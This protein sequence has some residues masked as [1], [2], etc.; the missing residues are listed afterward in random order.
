MKETVYYKPQIGRETKDI[1]REITPADQQYIKTVMTAY[2]DL[3][4][5]DPRPEFKEWFNQPNKKLPPKKEKGLGPNT[6]KTWCE[7]IISKLN[8]A[9]NRRDLSPKQCEGIEMLSQAISEIYDRC[10]SIEF[11][12]KLNKDD[13]NRPAGFG[14]LFK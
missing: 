1:L 14:K 9:P 4:T 7:G 3:E 11:K 13:D 10:P 6:P 12:N 8:Q 2:L 5:A